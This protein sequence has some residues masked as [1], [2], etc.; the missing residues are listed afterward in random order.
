MSD[1]VALRE[2]RDAAR[3]LDGVVRATPVDRPAF[4]QRIAGRPV[5]LKH[6]EQQRTGSFKVRGAY[7]HIAR[8]PA[9]RRAGGVVAVSAGNHAQGVALSASLLGADATIFMPDTAPLPK[10]EATR[11]Y[12]A[13][14]ELVAG[15]LV[16]AMRAAQQRAETTGADLVHPFDDRSVIAGQGTLGLELIEQAPDASTIVVPVGGGGLVSGIATVF[17][18]LRPDVRIVGVEAEGATPMLAARQAG[19]P[20]ELVRVQTIADGIA[21]HHVSDLT[22]AH[23]DSLVDDVVTVTDEEIARAM[24]LLLERRKA[25]VEPAGATSLAA[26]LAG[27]AGGD[28]NGPVLAVLSGGNVDGALLVRLIEHGLA[29]AGRYLV[30][31]VALADRPG[32]LARLLGLLA[33][34]GLNIIDVEHHRT[35]LDLPIQQVQVRLTVETRDP[36]HRNEVLAAVRAGGYLVDAG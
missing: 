23:V 28:P 33:Q 35:G 20:V 24:L 32:E 7:C 22:L 6:E 29:A 21:V 26:V 34:L 27:C 10:V 15:G 5:L 25:V 11:G 1:L 2:V 9:P 4:L 19:R 36:D 17:K 12:G 31:R 30:M 13:K 14:V 8:L 18:S 16:G 3:L